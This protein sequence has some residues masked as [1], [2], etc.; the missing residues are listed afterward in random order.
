MLVFPRQLAM[1]W[2]HQRQL[3][4]HMV[5]E[6][7]QPPLPMIARSPLQ[8]CAPGDLQPPA[9]QPARSEAEHKVLVQVLQS[10]WTQQGQP[11]GAQAVEG[12]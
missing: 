9:Q 8:S 12:R 11:G 10:R 4:E 1:P 5:W 7:H 6:P 2:A 3:M